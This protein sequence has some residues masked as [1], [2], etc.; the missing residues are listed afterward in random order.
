VIGVVAKEPAPIPAKVASN[1]ILFACYRAATVITAALAV[2]PHLAYRG[3]VTCGDFEMDGPFLLGPAIDEAASHHETAEGAFVWLTPRARAVFET[4]EKAREAQAP[5]APYAVPLK[6]GATFDTWAVSP[7]SSV[8]AP[9]KRGE[10]AATLLATFDKDPSVAVQI[11]RQNTAR[12][13]EHLAR[14]MGDE[15]K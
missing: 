13:L 12:F 6:G 1:S 7:F 11:K 14:R 5:V 15:Q 2:R 8:D 4:I 9:S 3:C 10:L